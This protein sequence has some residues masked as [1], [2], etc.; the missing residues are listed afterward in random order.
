MNLKEKLLQNP[1]LKFD[2]N[3]FLQTNSLNPG[4]F[5]AIYLELRRVEGRVYPDDVVK[6]LPT[7]EKEGPLRKE[8]SLRSASLTKLQG[9]L[10]QVGSPKTILELGSG[11]GWFA[12]RIA[13][14][15]DA[16]VC[17][18]DVNLT[19]LRQGA[20]VF[21]DY[22]NL[23]FIYGDIFT[24]DFPGVFFDVIIM[25]ASIQ[26]FRNL[27]S[28]IARLA[29]MLSGDGRIYILDT[30]FYKASQLQDARQRSQKYFDG[31]GSPSMA[32]HYFH[33]T[34]DDL[35]GFEYT[36]P[37]NPRS[38]SSLIRRKVFQSIEPVFPFVVVKPNKGMV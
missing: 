20:R 1:T 9:Y 11:N 33:H 34:L 15:F 8:W 26:Y 19:E 14:S 23:N 21:A 16:E 24:V 28:L 25:A 12:H 2:E 32:A 3:I 13:E 7:F 6:N 17:A 10:K 4:A 29:K 36:I 31:M 38:I 30:P 18:M 35:D 37:H 27:K 22:K 5:E